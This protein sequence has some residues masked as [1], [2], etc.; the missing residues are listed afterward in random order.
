MDGSES[1]FTAEQQKD[2]QEY[3]SKFCAKHEC[4]KEDALKHIETQHYLQWKATEGK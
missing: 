4:T 1:I 3:F 2:I